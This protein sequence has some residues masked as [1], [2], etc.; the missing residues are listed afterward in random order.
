MKL[1][2]TQTNIKDLVASVEKQLDLAFE[3]YAAN[4][5]SDEGNS[6]I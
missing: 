2:Q 5:A 4:D 6:K 1:S 3:N